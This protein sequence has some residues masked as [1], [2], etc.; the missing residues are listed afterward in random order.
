[1]IVPV[2]VVLNMTMPVVDV[3]DVVVVRYGHVPASRP[4]L[5][6]VAAVRGVITRFAFVDVI[7]VDLVQ[8]TVVDVVDVVVVRYGHVPAAE[9]VL[10]T[11][12]GVLAMFSGN[13]H[14]YPRETCRFWDSGEHMY[15]SQRKR[16][17]SRLPRSPSWSGPLSRFEWGC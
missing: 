2:A 10:V 8:V 16:Y 17:S 14:A 5:V 9:S 15:V 1:M 7:V 13:T 3:V 11:V 12:P 6:V 4:V